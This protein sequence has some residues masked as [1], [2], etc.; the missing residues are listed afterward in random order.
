MLEQILVYERDAFLWLNGLHTPYL[1]RFMWIYS[2]NPAWIPLAVFILFALCYRRPWRESVLL[3]LALA[4]AIT[5]CDQFASGFCKPFFAR[6]RPTRH[7]DFMHVV[8]TVISPRTGEPYLSGRYGF[9][10]SHAA[11]TFGFALFTSLLFRHRVY[12]VCLF[13]W[14]AAMSYTRIYLGVHFLSDIIPGALFGLLFSW[15]TFRLYVHPLRHASHSR[16]DHTYRRMVGMVDTMPPPFSYVAE[17]PTPRREKHSEQAGA[18]V[19]KD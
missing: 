17:R 3:I 1:D 7:P 8:Q 6:F 10:S 15:L 19:I 18:C 9:M 2:G 4:L 14:A 11:N 13:L 5:L 16:R 12:T